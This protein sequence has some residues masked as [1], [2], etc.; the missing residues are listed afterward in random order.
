[1][2]QAKAQ[3]RP[4]ESIQLD[5]KFNSIEADD[6]IDHDEPAF[7]KYQATAQPMRSYEEQ[8]DETNASLLPQIKTNPNNTFNS[9]SKNFPKKQSS[10][11]FN[12]R[13]QTANEQDSLMQ[14]D[15]K[16]TSGTLNRNE[17]Q[18]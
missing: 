15:R 1:M 14:M 10:N 16:N 4:Q 17:S 2:S 5:S 9:G 8:V 18:S 13:R 6:L 3:A 12:A 11:P 7:N